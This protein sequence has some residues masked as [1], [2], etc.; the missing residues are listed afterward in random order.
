VAQSILEQKAALD[1]KEGTVLEFL[2]AIETKYGIVISYSSNA[3]DLDRKIKLLPSVNSLG[4]VFEVLLQDEDLIA[5]V[6]KNKILLISNRKQEEEDYQE[7]Y[8]FSGYVLDSESGEPIIGATIFDPLSLKGTETNQSGYFNLSL[9][10]N[11]RNLVASYVGYQAQL[12]EPTKKSGRMSISLVP[13]PPISE[14]VVSYGVYDEDDDFIR[15]KINGRKLKEH[16]SFFGEKDPIRALKLLPGIQSGNEAQGGIYVRGGGAEHN[17]V[18]FDDVPMYEINHAFNLSSIFN[19]DAINKVTLYKNGVP[20]RFGGR[21]SSVID[22]KSKDG[23]YNENKYKASIDLLGLKFQAEGPFKKEVSSFN[24]SGRVSI[25][26]LYLDPFIKKFTD[27]EAADINYYDFNLKLNHHFSPTSKISLSSYVGND[28]LRFENNNNV[29]DGSEFLFQNV[30]ELKWSNKIFNVQWS[31]V[32][33]SK[34]FGKFST[35]YSNYTYSPRSVYAYNTFIQGDPENFELDVVA[36]SKM[37][38]LSFRSDFDYYSDNKNHIR[39]GASLIQHNF[40]PFVRQSDRVMFDEIDI[41]IGDENKSSTSEYSIYLENDLKPNNNLNIN[42]GLHVSGFDVGNKIYVNLEP[43]A[44]VS[45][46]F[47]RRSSV[48]T[49]FNAM[50]QNVHLLVN[51]GVGLP[52]DLWV[53]STENIPPEKSFNSSL[54][55]E[56]NLGKG[57]S[58]SIM[59]FVNFYKNIV[60]YKTPV[61]VYYTIINVQTT[62]PVFSDNSDWENRVELGN[63]ISKGLE[64]VLTKKSNKLNMQIAYTLA[65]TDR[66]FPNLN[67]GNSFP[68]RYDRRHDLSITGNLKLSQKINLSSTFIYGTGNAFTLALEEFES[69]EGL[70]LLNFEERNNFRM[71]AYHRLDVSLNYQNILEKMTIETSI[72]IQNVYNR[73]NPFYI[74][75]FQNPVSEIVSLKQVSIYPILPHFSF[76]INF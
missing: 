50:T 54:G 37:E 4:D 64:F 15:Y 44:Y 23:N 59:G 53:P 2:D 31:K 16:T 62:P 56:T 60:E 42:L 69:I 6:R 49:S 47:S 38:D 75:L 39:F 13:N 45:Y 28:N 10:I 9:S 65:K 29:L 67:K 24:F 7:D 55:I 14:V 58:Y 8:I 3:F 40:H 73:N 43:R 18:L 48:Y 5:Y 57:Y 12:I 22:I 32:I 63:S 25:I 17:L 11:Q 66:T 51:P 30:N 35:S 68:Y 19:V 26:D 52:T 36:R 76:S 61:D 70:P 74:Y 20:A 46:D 1:I 27:F 41:I 72:G 34:V 33:S 71:P 21:L